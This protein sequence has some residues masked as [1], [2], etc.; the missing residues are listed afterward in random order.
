MT[1]CKLHFFISSTG[2]DTAQQFQAAGGDLRGISLSSFLSVGVS[3]SDQTVQVS[4]LHSSETW[5]VSLPLP[6]DSFEYNEAANTLNLS[7]RANLLICAVDETVAL[8]LA[9]ATHC[10]GTGFKSISGLL[11]APVSSIALKFGA[12]NEMGRVCSISK[13]W[14]SI[15]A[16]NPPTLA[17]GISLDA[18]NDKCELDAVNIAKP[19][20]QQYTDRRF[21][22]FQS[23]P[24]GLSFPGFKA[25]RGL[26]ENSQSVVPAVGILDER[27]QRTCFSTAQLETLAATAI[28]ICIP[29]SDLEIFNAETEFPTFGNA[30]GPG[31]L[32]K[33]EQCA[34]ILSVM[35]SLLNTY[36]TDA[37]STVRE[38]KVA[39]ENVECWSYSSS[40][41]LESDDCDQG[42]M[43]AVAIARQAGLCQFGHGNHDSLAE[44]SSSSTPSIARLRNALMFHTVGTS[45]IVATTASASTVEHSPKQKQGHAMTLLVPTISLCL[46]LCEG[47]K[48]EG[49]ASAVADTNLLLRLGVCIP[50]STRSLVKEGALNEVVDCGGSQEIGTA[51]SAIRDCCPPCCVE[52]TAPRCGPMFSADPKVRES[53]S[54]NEAAAK[55]LGSF[56]VFKRFANLAFAEDG[57]DGFY[58]NFV[59][60]MPGGPLF[61]SPV[62]IENGIASG[63]IILCPSLEENSAVGENVVSAGVSPEAM[64]NGS[65]SAVAGVNVE[66]ADMKV[67]QRGLALASQNA[68]VQNATSRTMPS[69]DILE[70]ISADAQNGFS[71]VNAHTSEHREVLFLPMSSMKCFNMVAHSLTKLRDLQSEHCVSVEL[72]DVPTIGKTLLAQISKV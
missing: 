7:T 26:G 38:G 53:G 66:A 70:K 32:D 47:E 52:G 31:R 12:S 54:N 36:K 58:S 50:E 6:I 19:L 10:A 64:F 21:E 1:V 39:Q 20:L 13:A 23:D 55:S 49:V 5:E 59:E 44:A 67:L 60:L 65:Y 33:A 2:T 45:L 43:V 27:I 40:G 4:A 28:K 69:T 8:D 15:D 46:A 22:K 61:D 62:L 9:L 41:A 72:L 68:I 29:A 56:G 17:F 14:V 11:Q 30:A 35:T 25:H 71:D 48:A 42:S 57:K 16:K 18:T 34:G 51:W 24:V 63:Q 3:G 37:I